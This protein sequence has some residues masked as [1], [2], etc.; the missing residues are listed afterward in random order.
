MAG[1]DAATRVIAASPVPDNSMVLGQMN[2]KMVMGGVQRDEALFAKGYGPQNVEDYKRIVSSDGAANWMA[3]LPSD[4]GLAVAYRDLTATPTNPVVLQDVV[5]T[6]VV[7][8]AM[9]AQIAQDHVTIRQHPREVITFD[10]LTNLTGSVPVLGTATGGQYDIGDVVPFRVVKNGQTK[11][12]AL[13]RVYGVQRALTTE[14]DEI[15][16]PVLVPNA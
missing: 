3:A 13:M 12:N 11:I 2:L 15:T 7:I 16:A 8:A 4:D 6:D 14:G 10:P 5:Q 1:A 9:R